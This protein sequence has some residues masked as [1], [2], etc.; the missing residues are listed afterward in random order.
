MKVDAYEKKRNNAQKYM[1]LKNKEQTLQD[2]EREISQLKNQLQ[3]FLQE[4][5][6]LKSMEA[7]YK[8][9]NRELH[10]KTDQEGR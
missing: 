8:D 7:K 1:E 5:A 2:V 3:N 10:Q 4:L 9:E 6:H